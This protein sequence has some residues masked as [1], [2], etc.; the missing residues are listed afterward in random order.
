MPDWGFMVWK[1][2]YEKTNPVC[3]S[4][5]WRASTLVSFW[6]CA[7]CCIV[8]CDLLDG[9]RD[10]GLKDAW[11]QGWIRRERVQESPSGEPVIIL[12][13]RHALWR[14]DKKNS[15][16]C[17]EKRRWEIYTLERNRSP[18]EK[19]TDTETSDMQILHT[20]TH[21]EERHV[22]RLRESCYATGAARP[23]S[24]ARLMSLSPLVLDMPSVAQEVQITLFNPSIW[25]TAL[26]SAMLTISA[27]ANAYANI[28]I[29]HY[30][31]QINYQQNT[32]INK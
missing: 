31:T 3:S 16:T 6:L 29:N 13:E 12:T 20:Q 2:H 18:L 28:W 8:S 32:Y 11:I 17:W 4:R 27:Q 19:E 25:L 1:R 15:Y 14:A 9:R 26:N 24:A 21:S 22:G 23:V 30:I 7:P 10:G 5:L